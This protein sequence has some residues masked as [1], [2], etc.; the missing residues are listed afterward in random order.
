[1]IGIRQ[2]PYVDPHTLAQASSRLCEL[3]CASQLP[4]LK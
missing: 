4:M 3:G 1:M 2:T